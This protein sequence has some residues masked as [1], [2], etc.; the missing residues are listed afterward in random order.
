MWK[1]WALG[2]VASCSA[3]PLI[4]C[5]LCPPAAAVTAWPCRRCVLA[6]P[7]PPLFDERAEF[8]LDGVAMGARGARANSVRPIP[9]ASSPNTGA[10]PPACASSWLLVWTLTSIGLPSFWPFSGL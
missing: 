1:D 6:L 3:S 7:L 10:A 5:T 9:V 2:G 4:T 8:G